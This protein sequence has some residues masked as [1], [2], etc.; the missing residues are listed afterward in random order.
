MPP[1]ATRTH[2]EPLPTAALRLPAEML[3]PLAQLGLDRVGDLLALPRADLAARFSPLLMRRL[4]QALGEAPEVIVLPA[5]DPDLQAAETF[6]FPIE[7]FDELCQVIERLLEDVHR[8]LDRRDLGAR[9]L[10]CRLYHDDAPPTVL[11]V[12]LYRPTRCPRHLGE[13]LRTRLEQVQLTGPV[14][15]VS[16]SVPTAERIAEVQR[17]LFEH[18]DE[19]A[20][21]G[22]L[23]DRLSNLLGRDAV[24]RPCCVA[25]AQPECAYRFAPVS[26]RLRV[27]SSP[28]AAAN[29]QAGRPLSLWP[30]PVPVEVLAV[31][32]DGPPL[33]FVWQGTRWDVASWWGPERIETGWWRGDDVRRDYYVVTTHAGSRFWLFRRRD[34][35]RW[36]LHGCFD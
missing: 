4:D 21:L 19:E 13:L 11:E 34:D 23:I 30:A 28:H 1:G 22:T 7:R 29:P 33:R 31:Y 32:P 18:G 20:G 6:D 9:Q 25:D 36:F 8:A 12:G 3:R 27:S 17:A 14:A 26:S 24:T 10:E 35:G 5:A 16:V 15:A 2:I